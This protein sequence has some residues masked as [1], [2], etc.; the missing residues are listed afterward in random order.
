MII[1]DQDKSL[2]FA[3]EEVFP[4][5]SHC[6]VV[7]HVLEKIPVDL[8]KLHENFMKK[9]SKCIFK[10]ATDEKFGLTGSKMVSR[11]YQQ[12]N[13]WIQTLYEIRKK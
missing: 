6:F 5:S 2:R 12:K 10:L 4:C 1:T 3:L 8:E 11:F 7:W 9:F 13:D